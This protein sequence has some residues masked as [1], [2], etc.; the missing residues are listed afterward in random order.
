MYP[1]LC[2]DIIVHGPQI[3]PPVLKIMFDIFPIKESQ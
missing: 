1:K 2:E 3:I